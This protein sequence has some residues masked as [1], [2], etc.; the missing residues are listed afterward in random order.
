MCCLAV[1]VVFYVFHAVV[2]IVHFTG[3]SSQYITVVYICMYISCV[4]VPEKT[5]YMCIYMVGVLFCREFI[6]F[7]LSYVIYQYNIFCGIHVL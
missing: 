6:D 7:Q 3:M 4:F 5:F 2:Y 1:S